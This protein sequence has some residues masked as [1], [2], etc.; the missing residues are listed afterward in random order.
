MRRSWYGR[1]PPL[2]VQLACL[3]WLGLGRCHG[4]GLPKNNDV[5]HS[6]LLAGGTMEAPPTDLST[7]TIE[8]G[9]VQRPAVLIHVELGSATLPGTDPD[10]PQKVNQDGHF[11]F[12]GWTKIEESR[13]RV[14]VLG[15]L[16]GHG[17]KGEQVTSF[18]QDRLPQ[19]LAQHLQ[20]RDG[21]EDGTTTLNLLPPPLPQKDNAEF[22]RLFHQQKKDLIELGNA[23]PSEVH[24]KAYSQDR[25]AQA[26]TDAFLASHLDARRDLHVPTGRSGT[27]CVV[28]VLVEKRNNKKEDHDDNTPSLML[29]TAAVGDSSASLVTC[30]P[31]HGLHTKAIATTS[32][33]HH[34]PE[35]RE[36]VESCSKA[37]I[38]SSGNVFL[39]P[40]GIAMTRALGDAILLQAG[41]LPLPIIQ[42]HELSTS[43]PGTHYYICAGTDG[44]FDVMT[45]A[46]L[47]DVLTKTVAHHE[48][49]DHEDNDRLSI[50]NRS[51]HFLMEMAARAICSQAREAWIA[52]LPI[53]TKVDDVTCAIARCTIE[54][55]AGEKETRED[56]L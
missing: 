17:R 3:F 25:I 52:D 49:D 10:R 30:S 31:R 20:L 39:G 47:A 8:D 4:W 50:E 36:R 41:V 21:G 15:V 29:Y 1:S 7:S 35:E 28:C 19:R 38:D 45:N 54:H 33:V 46:R 43:E 12:Q 11:V 5:L 2:V 48:N 22:A 42:R 34:L 51:G 23:D 14:T 44:V 9:V 6:V 27:T 16:D 56:Q 32:T 26:L 18:L 40:V 13:S 53:E 55:V 24:N 37:R